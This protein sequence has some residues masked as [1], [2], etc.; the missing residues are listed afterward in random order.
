MS[1]NNNQNQP[2]CPTCGSTNIEKISVAKK[3]V[4]AFGFGL[5]S[6]TA[7]V[8]FIARITELNSKVK[9]V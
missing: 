4:G 6:K 5:F 1:C 8:N 7:K 9:D 3:A 2:K